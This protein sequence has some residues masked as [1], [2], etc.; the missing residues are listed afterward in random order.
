MYRIFESVAD[1]YDAANDRIS[2]GL[3]KSWKRMLTQSVMKKAK[4]THPVRFLDVCCGTGDIAIMLAKEAPHAA[5]TGVDFSPA[6]L[7]VAKEKSKQFD[8]LTW[9]CADAADLPF[10]DNVFQAVTISFGLRNT[11]D[12]T[13][14]LSEMIRVTEPGGSVHVLDSCV[15]DSKLIK[16]FY[17]LYFRHLLPVVGGGKEHRSEYRWLWQSTDAFLRKDELRKLFIRSGLKKVRS[18][19]RMFGACVLVEGLKSRNSNRIVGSMSIHGTG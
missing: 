6:M 5:V 17:T 14:V 19:S 16:P 18:Q 4:A 3:Q 7:A 8:N 10:E 15:V 11:T 9:S 2:L 1:G 12:Y 13:K